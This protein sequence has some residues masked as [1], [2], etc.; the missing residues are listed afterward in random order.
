MVVFAI[1]VKN[2]M[3]IKEKGK[4]KKYLDLAGEQTFWEPKVDGDNISDRCT[5]N[6]PQYRNTWNF[7]AIQ[8]LNYCY[9]VA[10]SK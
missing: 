1:L 10:I 4:R 9:Y 2:R 3:K 6:D 5:R 7:I 8:K